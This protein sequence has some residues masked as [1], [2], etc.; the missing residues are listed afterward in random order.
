MKII[1]LGAS[2]DIGRAALAELGARHDVI[3]AGRKSGDVRADISDR[4][5]LEEMFRKVGTV[6]AVISTA[7]SVHFGPLSD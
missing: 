4:A 5:S 1:L 3:T 7:G 2:G 6:D